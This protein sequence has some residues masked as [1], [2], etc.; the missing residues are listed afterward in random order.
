MGGQ[1]NVEVCKVVGV[2]CGAVWG[3]GWG[4]QVGGVRGKEC[5]CAARE[6]RVCVEGGGVRHGGGHGKASS[7]RSN[8]WGV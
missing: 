6:L 7:A 2:V 1:G 4:W 5:G 8:V 3:G